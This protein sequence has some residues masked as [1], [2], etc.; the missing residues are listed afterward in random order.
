[1]SMVCKKIA[2]KVSISRMGKP[3]EVVRLVLW[4]VSTENTFV[5][6]QD[7]VIEGGFTRV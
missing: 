1:M 5:S 3:E 2:A 7:I 4:L 6:A